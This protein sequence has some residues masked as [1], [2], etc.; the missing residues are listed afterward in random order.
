MTDSPARGLVRV[1]Q[2]AAEPLNVEEAKLF[3]RVDGEAEDGLIGDMIVAVR[4]IAEEYLQKSLMT[5]SWQMTL[6]GYAPSV[7]RLPRG[8]VQAITSVTAVDRLG[9]ATTISDAIYHLGGARDTLHCESSVLGHEVRI[10]YV[11]GY[12]D[13]EDVPAAI[14]QGLRIHLAAL[15]DDRL[16]GAEIPDAARAL[17]H[18]YRIVRLA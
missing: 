3:L 14:R 10:V 13:A 16:G 9:S 18:P 2:P 15:Y 4:E 8:P 12:G 11:A 7:I 1:A 5:Q 6:E 17:Y